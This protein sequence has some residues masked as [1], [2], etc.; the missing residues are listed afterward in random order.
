[1]NDIWQG[2]VGM[3]LDLVEYA[4][5]A[6]QANE[7]YLIYEWSGRAHN[8]YNKIIFI[9]QDLDLAQQKLQELKD[10]NTNSHVT[11]EPVFF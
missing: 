4:K 11:Y 10:T 5:A 3:T 8:H 9:T 7:Y 2:S 6:Q 1:M